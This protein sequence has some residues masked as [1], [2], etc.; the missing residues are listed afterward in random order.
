MRSFNFKG[1]LEKLP[2]EIKSKLDYYGEW[3]QNAEALAKKVITKNDEYSAI[4]QSLYIMEIFLRFDKAED[5]M[6]ELSK[7]FKEE[8]FDFKGI[9]YN[10]KSEKNFK[11]NVT[12]LLKIKQEFFTSFP[13][14]NKEQLKSQLVLLFLLHDLGK[15]IGFLEKEGIMKY[16]FC[17]M[18]EDGKREQLLEKQKIYLKEK[19]G[20]IAYTVITPGK[21]I[22]RD[23]LITTLKAPKPF[24]LEKL[25]ELK[26]EILDVTSAADHTLSLANAHS[27]A[28]EE[29]LQIWFDRK[30]NAD[31][32]YRFFSTIKW[33]DNFDGLGLTPTKL[34]TK[35]YTD[36][37]NRVLEVTGSYEKRQYELTIKAMN[38][39]LYK[40]S[41]C[42]ILRMKEDPKFLINAET[43][44]LA[45]NYLDIKQQKSAVMVMICSAFIFVK[46]P[47]VPSI[48]V[49]EFENLWKDDKYKDITELFT[50]FMVNNM[51]S[52]D[53]VFLYN[54][55]GLLHQIPGKG[56]SHFANNGTVEELFTKFFPFVI[57]TFNE[58]R[59]NEKN[60][61]STQ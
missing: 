43:A 6:L 7:D 57:K 18:V 29:Y 52:H 61:K 8:E 49:K 47:C 14:E 55:T 21:K 15:C 10:S 23:V 12:T 1:Y 56:G 42:R 53:P 44:S 41:K 46:T 59:D 5:I 45:W 13:N 37:L 40:N 4:R 32:K 20:Y 25:N 51:F 19:D 2:K 3:G 28:H 39:I 38:E 30:E 11:D 26:K 48:V 36:I 60:K 34:L 58:A 35:G 16:D 17:L 50:K 9:P 54:I 31:T 24:T 33:V 22:V 27:A